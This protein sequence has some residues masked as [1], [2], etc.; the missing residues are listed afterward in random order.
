MFAFTPT[1]S[2]LSIDS[3]PLAPSYKA[4]SKKLHLYSFCPVKLPNRRFILNSLYNKFRALSIVF[5][6]A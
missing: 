4:D 2:G 6:L 5:F 1:G 3:S